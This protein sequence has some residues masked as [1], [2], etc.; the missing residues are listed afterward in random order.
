MVSSIVVIFSITLM[1]KASLSV[2]D[3]SVPVSI[4]NCVSVTIARSGYI[5][6]NRFSVIES[7]VDAFI[8]VRSF[9]SLAAFFVNVVSSI[10]FS[11]I[12]SASNC[13]ILP[14]M[15]VVL[16]EPATAVSVFSLNGE[17]INICCCK[18]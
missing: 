16:P 15:V 6:D 12:W 13:F 3:V 18:L 1:N 9:N 11:G 4:L 10:S 7:I 5:F 14:T 17:A 8:P 2:V